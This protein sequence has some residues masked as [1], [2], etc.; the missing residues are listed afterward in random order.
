M[1]AFIIT[2]K[3]DTLHFMQ[4]IAIVQPGSLIPFQAN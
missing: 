2:I 1:H 4:A 3:S